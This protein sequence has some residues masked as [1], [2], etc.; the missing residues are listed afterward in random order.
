[1]QY[2]GVE[3]P[4]YFKNPRFVQTTSGA[5]TLQIS[6]MV[7]E[8]FTETHRLHLAALTKKILEKLTGQ[9]VEQYQKPS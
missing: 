9:T 3:F 7:G 5:F 4:D 6:E 1:M 8:S 2:L